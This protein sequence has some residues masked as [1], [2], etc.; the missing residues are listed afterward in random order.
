MMRRDDIDGRFGYHQPNG[1]KMTRHESVRS[2]MRE[3]AVTV[4]DLCPDGRE[5]S[6]AVEHLE[7]AMFWADAAIVRSE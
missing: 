2:V 5:K 7:E 1:D 6:L 4:N 3:A